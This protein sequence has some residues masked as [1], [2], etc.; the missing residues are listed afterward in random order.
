MIA[1]DLWYEKA[2]LAAEAAR[3][4]LDAGNLPA[5]AN[6]AYYSLHAFVNGSLIEAGQQPPAGRGNWPHA[7]LGVMIRQHLK[8]SFQR[9]LMMALADDLR[10]VRVYADYGDH[11]QLERRDLGDLLRGL[12]QVLGSQER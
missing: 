8:P 7:Q 9:R 4:E 5:S 3:R 10:T 12:G 11:R 1:S 6:R 2:N